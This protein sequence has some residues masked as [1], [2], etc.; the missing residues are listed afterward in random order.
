MYDGGSVT[1][2]TSLDSTLVHECGELRV[3]V[4]AAKM[5]WLV[6]CLVGVL[7]AAILGG[8]VTGLA[9]GGRAEGVSHDAGYEASVDGVLWSEIHGASD[10]DVPVAGSMRGGTSDATAEWA[11][12]DMRLEPFGTVVS[13]VVE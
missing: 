6:F 4:I 2:E 11:D 5:R 3:T 9:S 13:A 12:V 1:C 7:T 8:E 10:D